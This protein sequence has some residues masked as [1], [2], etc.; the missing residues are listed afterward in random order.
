MVAAVAL[1]VSGIALAVA[2]LSAWLAWNQALAA[3]RLTKEASRVAGDASRTA[4]EASRAAEDAARARDAAEEALQAQAM[5]SQASG[6]RREAQQQREALAIAERSAA[7]A[8]ESA[9][10]A[11][12]LAEAGQRAYV[13]LGSMQVVRSDLAAG[14]PTVVRCEIRN[15]GKT[16]AF[17]VSSWQWLRPLADLPAEP[18]YTGLESIQPAD[19]GPGSLQSSDA[20]SEAVDARVAH[21]VRSRELTLY[22]YGISRYT[23]IFGTARQTRWA[24]YWN[25]EK[26]QFTR[27]GHHNDM[28]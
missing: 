26:R 13:G 15:T 12:M 2:A 5:Q 14:F 9:R 18:D 25:F 17:S 20:G 16:P 24:F 1:C 6:F 28:T 7:A 11:R 22:L 4:A 3:Q 23:D 10:A 19:L 8:E 21:S 27:C